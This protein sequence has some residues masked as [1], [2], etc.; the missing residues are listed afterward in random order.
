MAV[1]HNTLT[2]N[3]R[4]TE[5]FPTTLFKPAR[6][7][8]QI[9]ISNGKVIKGGEIIKEIENNPNN[10]YLVSK[11][12]YDFFQEK[13]TK[14]VTMFDPSKTVYEDGRATYQGGLL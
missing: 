3:P 14:N 2:F 9:F 1:I 7:R 10:T 4:V 6:K 13:G 5:E 12:V 8:G 11:P